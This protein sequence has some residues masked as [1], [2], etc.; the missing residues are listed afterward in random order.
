MAGTEGDLFGLGEELVDV[1]VQ[2]ELADHTQG[3]L[4]FRPDLSGIEDV[5]LKLILVL[6]GDGLDGKIPLGIGL[7][8]DGLHQVLAVEVGI[9]T[10]QLQGLVPDE[11]V[12][13]EVRDPV[14]LDKV[15]LSLLVDQR[16]RVDTEALHHT[17]GPRDGAVR[18]RPHEHV[19]G[20]GVQVHKVPEIVMGRLGLGHFVVRLGL[21]SVDCRQLASLS[22]GY[23]VRTYQSQG[24]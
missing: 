8:V 3:H 6:L 11:R 15:A 14:E 4:L 12:H 20:F 2:F 16:E 17:V 24:T 9:L 18:H 1:A 19:R 21:D 13:S 10:R 23:L 7:V 5:E 22:R